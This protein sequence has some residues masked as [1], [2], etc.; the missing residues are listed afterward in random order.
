MRIRFNTMG[1]SVL[2]F[3]IAS[4][5]GCGAHRNQAPQA[6]AR[7][8]VATGAS[9]SAH[10]NA[11]I[12]ESTPEGMSRLAMQH[13]ERARM[14][15]DAAG[16]TEGLTRAIALYRRILREFPHYPRLAEVY[17]LFGHAYNDVGRVL[18]AQQVWRSLVCHNKFPAPIA[19]D[20]KQP[21]HDLVQPLPQDHDE[22]FWIAFRARY[23]DAKS[24]SKHDPDAVFIDPF[25]SDCVSLPQTTKRPNLTLNSLP[26]IWTRI[27]DWEFD[28]LDTG[29]GVIRGESSSV[30]GWNRAA[31]AYQH[32]LEWKS[33]PVYGLA[34]YKY[35]WTVFKQQR[36]AAAVQAFVRLLEHVDEQ[37]KLTGDLGTD[38]RREAYTYIAGS[39]VF[40]DFQGLGVDEPYILRADILDSEPRPEVV[41]RVLHVAIERVQYARIVPQTKMWTIEVYR[42]L[43]AEFRSLNQ[44]SN[45]LDVQAIILKRWPLSPV[46]PHVQ[47]AIAS[48]Y[49]LAFEL[50]SSSFW[51][52]R[53]ALVVRLSSNM[54]DI[55]ASAA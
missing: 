5:V 34:A 51:R 9:A 15:T 28:Q 35:A 27:G 12:V 24:L 53:H 33:A 21:E 7:A 14:N 55:L 54:P 41:E 16:K 18:E 31:S 3:M 23:P 42:A 13:T 19:D 44:Y 30:Y 49:Q 2:L 43:A 39:L 26:E 22:E 48:T 6:S 52:N 32:A 17:Y 50:S 38:Y 36:Y 29:S 8:P 46:A 10:P 47:A 37:Q 25:P 1:R 40:V 11:V 45:A 20:P 4:L